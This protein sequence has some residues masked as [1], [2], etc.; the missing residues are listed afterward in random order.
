MASADDLLTPESWEA[1]RCV[2]HGENPNGCSLKFAAKQASKKVHQSVKTW[3]IQAWVRRSEMQDPEDEP[4][5][6]LIA[7]Q[8]HERDLRQAQELR[9]RKWKIS[10]TGLQVVRKDGRKKIVTIK[11]HPAIID[12]ELEIRDPRYHKKPANVQPVVILPGKS[13]MDD[14]YERHQ[15]QKRLDQLRGQQ[16]ELPDLSENSPIDEFIAAEGN[17]AA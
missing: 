12:R 1:V 6:H 8:F 2:L 16:K 10:M 5:I 15:A 11:D 17:A 3:H 4:W 9:D 7:D 14:L 13:A